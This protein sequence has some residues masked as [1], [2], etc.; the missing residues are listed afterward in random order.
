[1][2]IAEKNVCAHLSYLV[3]TR[4]QSLSRSNIFSTL[5]RCLYRVLQYPA[6]DFR[7]LRG[8]IQG[9]IPLAFNAALMMWKFRR[10]N[11]KI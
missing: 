11:I 2:R 4:R 5:W 9:V 8:G 7:P 10:K 1:M 6:G 3:A